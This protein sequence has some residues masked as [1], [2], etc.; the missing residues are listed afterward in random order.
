MTL[1]LASAA[2]ALPDPVGP[3]S[4]PDQVAAA[5][6]A[7]HR[8]P[9]R[10]AY[11]RDLKQ[12]ADWLNTISI[13]P[14]PPA[15]DHRE[16]A[17][18]RRRL[19]RLRRRRTSHRPHAVPPRPPPQ[20]R[21]GRH[22]TARIG[23]PRTP[24]PPADCRGLEPPRPRP[25]HPPGAQRAAHLQH[26]A[27]DH[28]RHFSSARPHDPHHPP[29]RRQA[30]NAAACPAHSRR[31]TRLHRPAQPLHHPRATVRHLDR[32]AARPASRLEDHPTARQDSRDK[33]THLASLAPAHVRHP[34]PRRRR[35]PPRR[36]RRRR[37]RRPQNHTPVRPRPPQPRPAPHLRARRAAAATRRRSP[38]RRW[39]RR[40]G[41]IVRPAAESGS[42]GLM[43][44]PHLCRVPHRT[45]RQVRKRLREPGLALPLPQRL[46]AHTER[47]A[48]LRGSPQLQRRG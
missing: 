13:H 2:A 39:P 22:P 17:R 20:N 5:W 1:E 26:P 14:R 29:Q 31:A 21:P 47:L 36:P 32:P 15:R 6:L 18:R 44:R 37:S 33:Q 23:H 45:H 46:A 28:R 40:N 11:R 25:S 8:E 4:T 38:E 12:W 30:P 27:G 3:G 16:K 41:A 7:G 19:L 43:P 34:S 24:S 10:S 48:Q 35:H 42:A 9:T